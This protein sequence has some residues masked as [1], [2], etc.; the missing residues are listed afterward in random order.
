MNEKHE[1]KECKHEN[2]K[3][4]NSKKRRIVTPDF[5]ANAVTYRNQYKYLYMMK[6]NSYLKKKN[7]VGSRFFLL[8]TSM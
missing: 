6:C 2:S 7:R 8:K 3:N 5:L 4:N 1:H